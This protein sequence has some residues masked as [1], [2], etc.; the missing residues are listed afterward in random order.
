VITS[1]ENSRF[2]IMETEMIRRMPGSMLNE[3]LSP[4][5]FDEIALLHRMGDLGHIHAAAQHAVHTAE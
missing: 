1:N 3:H 4:G 5:Q 2:R